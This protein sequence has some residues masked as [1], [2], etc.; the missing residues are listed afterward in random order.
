MMHVD[1]KAFKEFILDS[2]LVSK[3]ELSRAE[4]ESAKKGTDITSIF[5]EEG[6]MTEDDVRRIHAHILGIPFVDLKKETLNLETLENV[7]E[8]ICR[9]RNIVA[10]KK[11]GHS[12][13]VALLDLTEL[14]ALDFLKKEG[15][16]ILPRLTDSY[17]M[18][19]ALLVYQKVLK[20]EFGEKIEKE[21][22]IFAKSMAEIGDADSPAADLEKLADNKAIAHIVDMILSHALAQHAADIHIEPRDKELG[23]R[24]RIGGMLHEAL[25]LPK[26]I[27]F[28]IVLRLKF[29]AGLE[30]HEKNLPQEGRF[31]MENENEK[32]AFRVSLV[33]TLFGEKVLLR[34]LGAGALG[35]TLETLGF[36]GAGLEHLHR[37]MQ[38]GSGATVVSGPPGSGK[39][40][41]L[42]TI[43][44][45]L[46]KPNVNIATIED[47]VEYQMERINQTQVK[48]DAGLSF[49]LG[50]RALMKQDADAMMVGDLRD[51]ETLS[52]VLNAV[53]AGRA[54]FAGMNGGSA[55]EALSHLVEM[56][57]PPFLVSTAVKVV[58]CGKLVKRLGKEKEAHLISKE[59]LRA[60][61]KIADM[62]R[63]LAALKEEE[64]V[65][66]KAEWQD[67]KA[68][69]ERMDKE[70]D[71]Y[72]GVH[73]VLY[74]S[75]G[76]QS[77]IT[78]ARSKD[79][80]EEVESQARAE[81]MLTIV[82]D[83]VFKAVEGLTSLEEVFRI[84]E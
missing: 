34:V 30:L 9:S 77:I 7:P 63:V 18:K 5:R 78:K 51:K 46:N 79:M 21:A 43:L 65:A 70:A 23:V 48:E 12:L 25:V 38:S 39:T 17:S 72:V 4:K 76:V 2:G 42:Y 56:G 47:P 31:R 71:E 57:G 37:V 68:F 67:V 10:F 55:A 50:L 66:K 6:L 22:A 24:Y 61:H 80:A 53:L 14:S 15:M 27:A 59:E 13:E 16:K 33:P 32:A 73:E 49:A 83:A 41:A 40:T 35:F 44:D 20:K 84:S 29:L 81:G 3:A 28:P 58:V 45:I 60:L 82:E 75:A 74:V 54:I 1:E 52:V 26:K 8:P 69:H 36:H 19:H 11:S 64:V 62:D